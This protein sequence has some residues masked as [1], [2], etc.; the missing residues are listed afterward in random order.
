[1]ILRRVLADL[2][3]S[4]L[5][6]LL[7]HGGECDFSK[8][9]STCN[10]RKHVFPANRFKKFRSRVRKSSISRILGR[11]NRGEFEE[12]ALN[13]TSACFG[14]C[15]LNFILLNCDARIAHVQ[16]VQGCANRSSFDDGCTFGK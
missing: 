5:Q 7:D 3:V 4:D 11:K 9:F 10:V 6:Q 15:D 2:F 13:S 14:L 1:M 12:W 16:E 8:V